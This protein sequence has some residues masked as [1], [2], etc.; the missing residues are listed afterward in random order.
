[1]ANIERPLL[2]IWSAVPTNLFE[3]QR[4]GRCARVQVCVFQER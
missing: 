1:L 4:V 2:P 3:R